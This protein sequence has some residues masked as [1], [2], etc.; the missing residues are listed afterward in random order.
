MWTKQNPILITASENERLADRKWEEAEGEEFFAQ[1]PFLK[2]LHLEQMRAERSGRRFALML[3]ESKDLLAPVSGN[4]VLV[5]LRSALHGATR[6][7][8]VTGW[9]EEGSTLG[10]IFTEIGAT[11]VESVM[12]ALRMKV[13]KVFTD[14]LTI[15]QFNQ[16]HISFHVF[17]G[18]QEGSEVEGSLRWTPLFGLKQGWL[19]LG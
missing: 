5:K 4:P 12:K 16:I 8:D 19:P 15:E 17:P 14:S 2:V 10:V 9:Y 6:A 18:L 13:T 3:I 1:G 7:T 11:D